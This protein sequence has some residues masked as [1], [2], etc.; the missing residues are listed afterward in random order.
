MKSILKGTNI[1]LTNIHDTVQLNSPSWLL[2]RVVIL[3]LNKLTKN[4]T[5]PLIHQKKLYYIQEKYPNLLHIYTNGSKDNNGTRCRAVFNKKIMK[6]YL[7]KEA[8]VFTTEI[9]AINLAHKLVSTTS[10]KRFII[11]SD[12][13][14]V[15][16]SIKN[17]KL[18]N[19]LS[20]SWTNST[21]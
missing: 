8:S 19:S 13:I 18:N 9:C 10:S 17:R 6:K 11:H 21:S 5:H 16:Q 2:K 14:S 1:S 3:D 12:S 7:P 20:N 4:K 15:L